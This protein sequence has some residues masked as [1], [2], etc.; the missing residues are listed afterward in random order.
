[1]LKISEVSL[2]DEEATLELEGRIAGPWVEEVRRVCEEL[3][4]R[5]RRL[6]LNLE[7]V[8]F[9]D[10][11]AIALLQRLRRNEIRIANCS[12]FITEQLKEDQ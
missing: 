7:K 2:S 8:S 3:L 10:R 6:T 1:M 5:G 11:E 12:P 9:I 4:S